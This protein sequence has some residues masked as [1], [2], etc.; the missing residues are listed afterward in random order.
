M[1]QYRITSA[2][3]LPTSDNDCMLDPS[4]PMHD[5]IAT[6]CIGGIGSGAALARYNSTTLPII[7]ASNKGKI[8]REQN[9]KPG[10]TEWFDLW[11]GSK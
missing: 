2:D 9:I 11:F 5:L 1:R 7:N 4:D 3:I 6:S 10:T 8:Q